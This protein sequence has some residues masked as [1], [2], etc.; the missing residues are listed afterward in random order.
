MEGHFE[1]EFGSV[2]IVPD[3][4]IKFPSSD[5]TK[6]RRLHKGRWV[7]VV[8]NDEN[9][10]NPIY[11]TV[12]VAPCSHKI[13]FKKP[14]DVLLDPSTDNVEVNCM[15]MISQIQPILKSDLVEYK[16][17]ISE[18]ARQELISSIVDYFG[19]TPLFE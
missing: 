17:L 1:F 4:E 16:G 2:W 9:N 5:R 10:H 3:Q 13:Q 8:S 14:H 12:L 15:A 19:I 18:S 11:P 7:V 6:K